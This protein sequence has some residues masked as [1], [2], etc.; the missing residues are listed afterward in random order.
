VASGSTKTTVIKKK[1][2]HSIAV[3]LGAKGTGEMSDSKKKAVTLWGLDPTID[4]NSACA[5]F[6]LAM[7]LDLDG[8]DEKGAYKAVASGIVEQFTNYTDM[9]V[10]GELRHAVHKVKA[11][12]EIP[13]RLSGALK[14][15]L[16]TGSR[17]EAWV[18]WYYLRLT[19]GSAALRWAEETFKLFVKGG[20]GGPAW[21]GIATHLRKWEEGRDNYND[22]IFVDFCWG[23]EHNGGNYFNKLWKPPDAELLDAKQN[24]DMQTI[25][26]FAKKDMKDYWVKQDKKRK[27]EV[28]SDGS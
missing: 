11:K 8:L 3:Q 26:E 16:R 22:L 28:A 9:V 10:G 20:Y 18:A 4:L 24:S 15:V 14:S 23:L 12:G 1:E 19:Y 25:L 7:D 13:P 21:A 6:Y 2:K 27:E 5:A 17:H